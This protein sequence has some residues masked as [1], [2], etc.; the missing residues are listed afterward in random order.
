MSLTHHS[1]SFIPFIM[2]CSSARSCH[3]ILILHQGRASYRFST[4]SVT[5]S[6]LILHSLH[7]SGHDRRYST[8]HSQVLRSLISDSYF[9][10]IA[11]IL[12]LPIADT[13]ILSITSKPASLRIVWILLTISRTKPS[14]ISSGVRFV[15][16]T[17]V[18][19]PSASTY[20]AL[21]L[22]RLDQKIFLAEHYFRAIYVKMSDRTGR[23]QLVHRSSAIQCRKHLADLAK[24]FAVLR[25]DS[26]S[27]AA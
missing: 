22:R 3:I 7:V 4:P 27:A 10:R 15:S 11:S 24:Q 26:L 9:F 25:S 12:S 8:L 13:V 17:T 16:S 20:T 1:S 14:S 23:L 6:P 21:C 19:S 18:T 2:V 5:V